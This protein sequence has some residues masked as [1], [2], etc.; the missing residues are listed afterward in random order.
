MRSE[1]RLSVYHPAHQLAIPKWRTIGAHRLRVTST[2]R[3]CPVMLYCLACTMSQESR[4][5]PRRLVAT[6]RVSGVL[7]LEDSFAQER[8]PRRCVGPSA[9]GRV[10]AAGHTYI[11][12]K[13]RTIRLLAFG[14]NDHP[15]PRVSKPIFEPQLRM[16][17][18]R[19]LDP[20]NCKKDVGTESTTTSLYV[21][22]L[23]TG[24]V[25]FLTFFKGSVDGWEDWRIGMIFS[26]QGGWDARNAGSKLWARC[27]RRSLGVE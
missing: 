10:N 2:L 16:S 26:E 4:V 24:G 6:F 23:P 21:A 17:G 19:T 11:P 18:C 13:V 25:G 12:R 22:E 14:G 15:R 1:H 9:R 3:H 5:G 27:H 7:L 8:V 20:E